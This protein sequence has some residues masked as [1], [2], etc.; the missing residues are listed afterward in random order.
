LVVTRDHVWQE[1]DV[2]D[3]KFSIYNT[4][5]VSLPFPRNIRKPTCVQKEQSDLP[6][7]VTHTAEQPMEALVQ[8]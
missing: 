5:T 6:S 2:I 7:A 8:F 1:A 4:D 3:P